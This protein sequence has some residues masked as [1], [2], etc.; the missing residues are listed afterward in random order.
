MLRFF[1][2]QVN[3]GTDQGRIKEIEVTTISTPEMS[4][5]TSD[6]PGAVARNKLR[7]HWLPHLI[8]QPL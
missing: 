6:L 5:S 4:G 3:L 2:F 1:D 8:P 7:E